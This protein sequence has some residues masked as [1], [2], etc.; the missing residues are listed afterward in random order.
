MAL[1]NQVLLT[2]PYA[3]N[4][5]TPIHSAWLLPV[6]VLT[7]LRQ[8]LLTQTALC[9]KSRHEDCLVCLAQKVNLML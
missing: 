7:L 5:V 4:P 3:S 9:I 2:Q 6:D 1:L 8:V